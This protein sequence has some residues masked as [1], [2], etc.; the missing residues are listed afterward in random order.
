M[1][2]P[3]AALT[4]HRAALA[5]ASRTG[6]RYEQARARDGMAHALCDTGQPEAAYEHW[7]RALAIYSALGV[8][9]ADHVRANL[10][11]A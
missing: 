10:V 11:A 2:E 1:A 9:E 8:P 5:L 6:D 7:R 4:R 3:G